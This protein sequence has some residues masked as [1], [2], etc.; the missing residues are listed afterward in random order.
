M[1]HPRSPQKK[2]AQELAVQTDLLVGGHEET[3]ARKEHTD[4]P[5][6]GPVTVRKRELPGTE[7]IQD[8]AGRPLAAYRGLDEII[9]KGLLVFK[10]HDSETLG[11]RLMNPPNVR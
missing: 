6:V 1:V 3:G 4:R 9:Q 11:S 8:E 5:Q 2:K 7:S 10:C